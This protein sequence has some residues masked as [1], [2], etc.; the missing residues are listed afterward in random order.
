MNYL[1]TQDK[2]SIF[3]NELNM[4]KK[5]CPETISRKIPEANIQQS[6][7]LH[8]ALKYAKPESTILSVGSY[9]DTAS[10][11]L[12]KLNYNITEID[13]VIN[14]D[15]TTFYNM[16]THAKFDIVIST[17]VIE[18]VPDDELF[19]NTICKLLNTNGI[20]ILTCDFNNKYIT[21]NLSKPGEDYRLYTEHDLLTRL[22]SV[23]S[24][25]GCELLTPID[26]SGEP[27]F[28]YCGHVY[29]FASYIFKKVGDIL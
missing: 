28:T 9:E 24:D 15:L 18:H 4:L 11:T 7:V 22:N 19:I 12:K 6:Y 23:L 8:M 10:E 26:Y 2:L 14:Y 5:H 21:D 25:N 16:N 27:D 29:T 3:Q 20:G 17:S 1:L 13:P